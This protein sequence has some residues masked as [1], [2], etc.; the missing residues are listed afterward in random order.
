MGSLVIPLWIVTAIATVL[1]LVVAA[2][3]ARRLT[4]ARAVGSFDCSLLRMRADGAGSW[5]SG[6]ASY[7]TGELRWYRLFSLSPRPAQ[8]WRRTALRVKEFRTPERGEVFAVLPGAVVVTCQLDD[9]DLHLAMGRDAYN[10]F[11]S[12]VEAAPPGQHA[13]VT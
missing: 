2:F 8:V 10:G 12:W 3:T 5:V 9:Q 13:R 4:L 1:L 7:G 6:V 11:A